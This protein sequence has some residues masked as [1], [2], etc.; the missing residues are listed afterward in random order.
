[1]TSHLSYKND[2]ELKRKAVGAA[3]AMAFIAAAMVIMT[4]AFDAWVWEQDGHCG[5]AIVIH[6]LRDCR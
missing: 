3:A 4:L 2:P 1:M 5:D 6:H